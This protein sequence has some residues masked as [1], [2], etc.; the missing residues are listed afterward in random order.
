M[1]SRISFCRFVRFIWC[2][3][4]L[5]IDSF[6][7]NKSRPREPPRSHRGLRNDPSARTQ[8]RRNSGVSQVLISDREQEEFSSRERRLR[9]SSDESDFPFSEILLAIGKTDSKPRWTTNRLAEL[10]GPSDSR[11]PY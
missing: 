6:Y 7:T 4:L 2:L 1:K 10:L 5:G 8:N 3:T 11:C 9:F